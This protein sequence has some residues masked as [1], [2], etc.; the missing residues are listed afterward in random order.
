[1]RSRSG[2]NVR[3]LRLRSVSRSWNRLGLGFKELFGLHQ[4]FVHKLCLI[5]GLVSISGFLIDIAV[6]ALPLQLFD[7]AWNLDVV[8]AIADRSIVLLFGLALLAWALQNN[9]YLRKLFSR[10]CLLLGIIIL[11]LCILLFQSVLSLREDAQASIVQQKSQALEQVR[12]AQDNPSAEAPLLTT[13]QMTSAIQQIN[14]QADTLQ[15]NALNSLY[16]NLFLA[17]GNLVV[18]SLGAI[19]LSRLFI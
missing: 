8:R 15:R 3:S 2:A 10:F 1:M 4:T 18:V 7:A 13:E 14:Q 9:L 11:L 5:M 6:V 16:R 19:A 17:A 12:S